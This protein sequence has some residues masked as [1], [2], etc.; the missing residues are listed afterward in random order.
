MAECKDVRVRDVLAWTVLERLGDD[1]K[2]LM[3]AYEFMGPNTKFLSKEVEMFW[4]RT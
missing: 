4:G 2:Q 3:R 1:R